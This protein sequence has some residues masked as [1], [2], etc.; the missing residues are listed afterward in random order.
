MDGI[1]DPAQSGVSAKD[2]CPHCPKQKKQNEL[3]CAE[4][5][6]LLKAEFCKEFLKNP[7]RAERELEKVEARIPGIRKELKIEA[8][9]ASGERV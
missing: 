6:K 4:C 3:L 1:L 8:V 7:E 9:G 2:N 5:R